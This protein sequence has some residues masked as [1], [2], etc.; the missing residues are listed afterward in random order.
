MRRRLFPKISLRCLPGMLGLSLA[1]AAIAGTYGILHDQITYSISEEYF[2]RLKFDQF[3]DADFGLPRRVFVTEIG[4]LATWWVGFLSAWFLS[5]IAVP[6]WSRSLATKLVC[7]GCL[8]ICAGA[9]AGG[10]IGALAGLL[11]LSPGGL[12]RLAVELGVR[13]TAAFV[14]VAWIHN[15]GY[16]GALV[17]CVVAIVRL[18]RMRAIHVA[19]AATG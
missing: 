8:I 16:L 15:T 7:R 13:D 12:H 4:F 3:H 10:V 1:G 5:R 14:R 18:Q 2:T 9:L 17:G 6:C 19:S 11:P